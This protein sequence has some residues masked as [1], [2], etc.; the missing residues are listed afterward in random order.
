MVE[1]WKRMGQDPTLRTGIVKMFAD[2]V[3]ES[4]TAAMLAPYPNS[5]SAG[6]PH[7]AA[8]APKRT[9]GRPAEPVGRG[10]EP[11]R[12]H[13]RQARAAGADPRDRRPGHPDVARR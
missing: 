5:K 13:A 8:E 11:G 7:P 10:A 2:G 12:G 9:D 1:T 6:P 4:R 3:I